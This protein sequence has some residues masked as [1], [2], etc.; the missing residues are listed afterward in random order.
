MSNPLPAKKANEICDSTMLDLGD[1][2][3]RYQVNVLEELIEL[4]ELEKDNLNNRLDD[5]A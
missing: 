1:A 4:L 3:I 2:D 5:E